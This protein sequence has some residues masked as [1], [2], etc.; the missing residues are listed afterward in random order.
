MLVE[1]PDG[2]IIYAREINNNN[3][4]DNNNNDNQIDREIINILPNINTNTIPLLNDNN[5]V[6]FIKTICLFDIIIYF[7]FFFMN[8]SIY[9]FYIVIIL[10][11]FSYLSVISLD[12]CSTT[13]NLL[14]QYIKLFTY[15]IYIIIYLYSNMIL[16]FNMELLY[17]FICDTYFMLLLFITTIQYF[18]TYYITKFFNII[19]LRNNI[20]YSLNSLNNLEL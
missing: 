7:N 8:S 10:S 3:N 11:F 15:N 13:I 17:K 20:I 14:Y 18:I 16:D 2:N 4:N 5:R 9:V 19:Y 1:L 12:N 6:F